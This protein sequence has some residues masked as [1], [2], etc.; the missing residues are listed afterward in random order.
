VGVGTFDE[1]AFT[2]HI[3]RTLRAAQGCSLEI[4]FRD[5]YTLDGDISKPGRAVR[6]V[7]RLVE[8][9]WR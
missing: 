1:A 6:V 5:I 9:M 8:K 4:I 3:A 7:R 2:A